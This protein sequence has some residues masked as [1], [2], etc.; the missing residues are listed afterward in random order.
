VW[1]VD[2]ASADGSADLVS[3]QF[4][5]VHLVRNDHNA[6]FAAAN[7]QALRQARG[8]LLLLLNSDAYLRPGSLDAFIEAFDRH[9]EMGIAGAS[10]W[11]AD[12]SPQ[13][14][15]GDFPRPWVEFL[16]QS[17]L[18]KV[19]PSPFPYG[20]RVHPLLRRAYRRFQWVDWVTG[21]ALMMRRRVWETIGGLPEETFMYGEDMAYCARAR[22]AGFRVG[23]L[24][25]ARVEHRLAGSRSNYG[26]WIESYTRAT[27][28]YYRRHGRAGDL[29][30]V[31][32]LVRMGSLWRRALWTVVGHLRPGA[33]AEAAMRRAGYRRAAALARDYSRGTA[34]GGKT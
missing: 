9:P 25:E 19:W 12:G 15:W 6:G 11:N 22:A 10:L 13:P 23:Y 30:R 29:A 4:P 2:N 24:P 5:E 31:A 26:D 14:S 17:L 27:L 21:A 32:L 28:E 20:R 34:G 8:E 3:S 18:F 33:R 1:V 7:N 16:F